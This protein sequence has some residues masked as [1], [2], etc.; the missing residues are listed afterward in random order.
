ML[1][2]GEYCP[3]LTPLTPIYC[4]GWVVHHGAAEA[5]AATPKNSDE[6]EHNAIKTESILISR[7][8][9]LLL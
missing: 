9:S 5:V 2:V 6:P 4:D 1:P 3:V 7:R 8:E